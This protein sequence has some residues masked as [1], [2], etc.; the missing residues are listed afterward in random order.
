MKQGGECYTGSYCGNLLMPSSNTFLARSTSPRRSSTSPATVHS[1]A[2][3]GA[4]LMPCI[5]RLGHVISREFWTK[6]EFTCQTR[7]LA[8][9]N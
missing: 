4:F 5:F 2:C 8:R 7:V 9:C 3:G 1:A 6:V